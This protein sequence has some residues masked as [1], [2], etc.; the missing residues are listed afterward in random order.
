[1]NI[2]PMEAT[3]P[4]KSHQR[5]NEL[6]P[7][8]YQQVPDQFVNAT[9]SRAFS[10][11]FSFYALLGPPGIGKTRQLWAMQQQQAALQLRGFWIIKES[12]DIA[13]H[14]WDNDWLSAW[15]TFPWVLAIDDLGYRHQIQG[16]KVTDWLVQCAHVISDYRYE[17]NLKTIWT[18]NL[19]KER[20]AE[21]YG[22]L[23]ASRICSGWCEPLKGEDWRTKP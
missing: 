21:M 16:A 12:E 1:M 9:V 8:K 20:I 2:N 13:G 15:K 23:V 4:P 11:G 22:K 10:G 17:R 3:K 18:S 6:W 14:M 5:E 19:S 7:T